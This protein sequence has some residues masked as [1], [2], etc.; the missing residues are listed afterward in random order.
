MFSEDVH[1]CF[2][3]LLGSMGN[4]SSLYVDRHS[5]YKNLCSNHMPLGD[6]QQG[7]QQV[8]SDNVAPQH[9]QG[10]FG[11]SLRFRF[12][13]GSIPMSVETSKNKANSGCVTVTSLPL[14]TNIGLLL[15]FN[16]HTAIATPSNPTSKIA[17]HI[18]YIPSSQ[19]PQP[20]DSNNTHNSLQKPSDNPTRCMT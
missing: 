2:C 19:V 13:E 1:G 9:G 18:R 17:K 14:T 11:C 5:R 15:N 8:F 12:C 7:T 4:V 6:T 10:R 20:Q 16:F 3:V